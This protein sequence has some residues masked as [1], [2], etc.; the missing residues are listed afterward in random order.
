MTLSINGWSSSTPSQVEVKPSSSP[1]V[2]AE[3]LDDDEAALWGDVGDDIALFGDV[4]DE[5]ALW[6]DEAEAEPEEDRPLL[7]APIDEERSCKRCYAVDACMLFRK[8]RSLP[9]LSKRWLT[10]P[11]APGGR[12]RRRDSERPG[13][14]IADPV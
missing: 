2:K 6:G 3:V 7:P 1:V 11:F 14:A 13:C 4:D 9:A 10:P 8:V 12:W 5:Q